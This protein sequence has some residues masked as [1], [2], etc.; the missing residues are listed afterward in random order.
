M[1]DSI[2]IKPEILNGVEAEPDHDLAL[3]ADMMGGRIMDWR[4]AGEMR[5]AKVEA[6]DGQG[7]WFKGEKIAA[8]VVL[9]M[10]DDKSDPVIFAERH[11]DKIDGNTLNVMFNCLN[12][13]EKFRKMSD[14]FQLNLEIANPPETQKVEEV[15]GELKNVM[16]VKD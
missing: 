15:R 3:K 4:K 7:L 8:K 13:P 6:K 9:L 5:L 14:E 12:D 2:E 1:S 10:M 16:A 11:S